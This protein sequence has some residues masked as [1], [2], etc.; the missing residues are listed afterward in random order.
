MGTIVAPRRSPV[1]AP[2]ADWTSDAA[3]L[4]LAVVPRLETH[5]NVRIVGARQRPLRRGCVFKSEVS[6]DPRRLH[7]SRSIR[8][9]W[10]EVG[11]PPAASI[12]RATQLHTELWLNPSG[13]L[14]SLRLLCDGARLELSAVYI[15]MG[16]RTVLVEPA[17]RDTPFSFDVGAELI[18][19]RFRTG[20][21]W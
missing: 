17:Y 2:L 20:P 4:A 9:P 14:V 8:P 1:A 18:L 21:F 10:F 16:A 5:A 7:R 12:G 13:T 6:L 11:R 3:A 15:W 19:V